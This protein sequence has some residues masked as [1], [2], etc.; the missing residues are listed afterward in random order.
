MTETT[1][2][3]VDIGTTS[4]KASI[5]GVFSHS[6]IIV[7]ASSRIHYPKTITENK[8]KES[9]FWLPSLKEALFDLKNKCNNLEQ[10]PFE[11]LVGICISGNGPTIVSKDGTTLLWNTP[12]TIDVPKDCESLFIPRLMQFKYQF[13]EKWKKPDSML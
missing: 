6:G 5:S 1:V 8:Y 11:T 13:K 9:D 7:M 2:L 4:L 12:I 3:S 10:N